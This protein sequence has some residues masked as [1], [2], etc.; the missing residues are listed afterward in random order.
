MVSYVLKMILFVLLVLPHLVPW[1]YPSFGEASPL[2]AEILTHGSR[3]RIL[4]FLMGS[5]D[6][7]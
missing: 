2:E 4:E 3:V 6:Q 5:G 7:M 1:P